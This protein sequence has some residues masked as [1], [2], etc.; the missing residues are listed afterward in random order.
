MLKSYATEIACV[1]QLQPNFSRI[2]VSFNMQ[3]LKYILSR[4]YAT[5]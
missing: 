4:M 1:E 3:T 2:R 5:G